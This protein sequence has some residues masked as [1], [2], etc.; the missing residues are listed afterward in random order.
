MAISKKYQGVASNNGTFKAQI[1]RRGKLFYLGNYP[2]DLKAAQMYDR[3]HLLTVAYAN[4]RNTRPNFDGSEA[5][6]EEI[7]T[8]W[9]RE[10]MTW[11]RTYH[12]TDEK[13]YAESIRGE[14]FLPDTVLRNN[15]NM[16]ERTKSFTDIFF[17]H[18]EDVEQSL[19]TSA[20]EMAELKMTLDW[21][22]A[23]LK[24]AE[25]RV[26]ELEGAKFKL[27]SLP[28]KKVVV[29]KRDDAT[30]APNPNFPKPDPVAP[31]PMV[32][33]PAVPPQEVATPIVPVPEAHTPFTHA[34]DS[35]PAASPGPISSLGGANGDDLGM[36]TSNG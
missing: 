13:R 1:M 29:P 9:E 31:L 25:E 24:V 28:F 36:V 4:V 18:L 33:V 15:M 27:P 8:E 5:P 19:R 11:L 22:K 17:R 35:L 14:E 16:V 26:R 30:P 21:Y 3:A 23:Q 12:P 34:P 20:S 2:T 10:M 7:W 32:E 6:I